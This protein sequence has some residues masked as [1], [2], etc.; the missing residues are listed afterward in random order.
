MIMSIEDRALSLCNC[1]PIMDG[2][3][4][5]V[6]ATAAPAEPSSLVIEAPA[7]CNAVLAAVTDRWR[8]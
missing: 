2:N 3:W 5:A 7:A 6:R 8:R 4:R 1:R